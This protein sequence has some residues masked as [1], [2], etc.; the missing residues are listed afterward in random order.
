MGSLVTFSDPALGAARACQGAATCVPSSL[1]REGRSGVGTLSCLVT[2]VQGSAS[3][4]P[5]LSV[6]K[7]RSGESLHDHGP[8]PPPASPQET[9]CAQAVL[10][11]M[12]AVLSPADGCRPAPRTSLGDGWTPCGPHQVQGA[13]PTCPGSLPG[14]ARG[15]Q[16]AGGPVTPV[17]SGTSRLPMST[18][19]GREG[20][21][22]CLPQGPY[23]RAEAPSALR[24]RWAGEQWQPVPMEG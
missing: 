20:I 16:L 5:S 3:Q 17:P 10:P 23:L 1:G 22:P 8:F 4:P 24:A 11:A 7:R 2:L 14:T 21:W 15:S 13:P 6:C 12:R 9:S 19:R 18:S